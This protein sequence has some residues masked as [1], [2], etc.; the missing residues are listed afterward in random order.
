VLL[1]QLDITAPTVLMNH[2]TNVQLGTIA[3]Q[4]PLFLTIQTIF[5]QEVTT[6]LKALKYQFTVLMVTTQFLELRVLQI[7]LNAMK[8]TTVFVK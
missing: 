7:V 3:T 5:A 8:D 4:A 1:A 6:A 2:Q